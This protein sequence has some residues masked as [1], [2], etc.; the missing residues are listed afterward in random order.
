MH[1]THCA[2]SNSLRP[3]AILKVA[4]PTLCSNGV[5]G[6]DPDVQWCEPVLSHETFIE[7]QFSEITTIV[8][9]QT[10]TFS[11]FFKWLV[12]WPLAP[13]LW[14]LMMCHTGMCFY[15]IWQNL[16]R[17]NAYTVVS[18]VCWLNSHRS[19]VC[20]CQVTNNNNVGLSCELIFSLGGLFASKAMV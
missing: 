11:N 16:S 8:I 4:P 10:V 13:P 15:L 3:M 5:T 1:C 6:L 17:H 20:Q 14:I 19:L 7:K 9:L 2:I 18:Q 12:R